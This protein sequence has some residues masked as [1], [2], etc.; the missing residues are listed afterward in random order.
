VEP[1]ISDQAEQV[2]TPAV[3]PLPDRHQERVAKVQR[4]FGVSGKPA[5]AEFYRSITID[6]KRI[7]HSEYG[8]WKRKDHAKCGKAKWAALDLAANGLK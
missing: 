2:A 1:A 6:G 4:N 5:E 7:S 8:A 3:P